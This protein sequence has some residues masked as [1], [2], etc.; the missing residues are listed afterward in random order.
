MASKREL[1]REI[2]CNRKKI[3]RL[4]EEIEVQTRAD[5][6]P[7]QYAYGYNYGGDPTLNGKINAIAEHLGITFEVQP[8][9]V[10]ASKVIVKTKKGNK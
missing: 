2:E 7:D 4:Q 3:S 1:E 8:E 6:T 5:L 10:I 9:K